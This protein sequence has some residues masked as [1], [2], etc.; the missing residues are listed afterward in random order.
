MTFKKPLFEEA[1]HINRDH[2]AKMIKY[3]NFLLDD[4]GMKTE[5]VR[6]SITDIL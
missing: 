3:W 2:D 5:R 4:Y 1:E 6:F